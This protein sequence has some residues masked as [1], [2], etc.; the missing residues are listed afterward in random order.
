MDVF[1]QLRAAYPDDET[2]MSIVRAGEEI[3]TYVEPTATPEGTQDAMPDE[4][5]TPTPTLE[6]TPTPTLEEMP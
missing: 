5:I 2:I 6:M 3:C 1:D 4:T